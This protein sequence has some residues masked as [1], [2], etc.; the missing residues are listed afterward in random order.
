MK[1]IVCGRLIIIFSLISITA[2][3]ICGS[4]LSFE[5]I[6][7]GSGTTVKFNTDIGSMGLVHEY[8]SGIDVLG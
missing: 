3:T 5:D 8:A 4:G 1:C 2:Y 7:L 6:D